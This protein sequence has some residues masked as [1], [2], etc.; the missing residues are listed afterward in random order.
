[1]I[2]LPGSGRILAPAIKK[3]NP[4]LW[5]AGQRGVCHLVQRPSRLNPLGLGGHPYYKGKRSREKIY[6]DFDS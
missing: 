3:F 1:M 6:K 5:I 2:G 4:P